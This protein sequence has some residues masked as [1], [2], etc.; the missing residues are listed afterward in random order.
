MVP[1]ACSRIFFF[2][3]EDV[4]GDGCGGSCCCCY[5]KKPNVIIVA[6]YISTTFGI[7]WVVQN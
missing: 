4:V 5:L 6:R 7:V 1:A 3:G 2:R